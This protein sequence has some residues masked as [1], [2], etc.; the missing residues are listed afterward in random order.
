MITSSLAERLREAQHVVVFT[1]ARASA[2][3]G[4]P[5]FIE[6]G[7]DSVKGWIARRYLIAF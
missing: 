3:S 5:T 1:G 2:E 4:I 7:G 6:I